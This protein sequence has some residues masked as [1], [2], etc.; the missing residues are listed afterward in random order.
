MSSGKPVYVLDTNILIEAH[1][2]YYAFDLCPGFWDFLIASHQHGYICSI[3]RVRTELE[4]GK[5]ELAK[6]IDDTLPGSFFMPTA[7][8]SVV[9]QYTG[10]ITWVNG[11][12]FKPEAKAEFASV[13][14]GWLVAYA[15]ANTDHIVVTHEQ[16]RP[17]ARKKVL[18]P[19]VCVEF[20][21]DYQDT[22]AMLKQL[23]A[24][25]TWTAP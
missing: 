6:W 13:A 19:D 23:K 2:R 3:D 15:K 14:D 8:A 17:D 5:D 12:G 24:S 9:A 18:I 21:V 25:F 1:R 4:A 11:R 16:P 10:M 20:K 7:S 22:F